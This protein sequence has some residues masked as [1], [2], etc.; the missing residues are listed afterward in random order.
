MEEARESLLVVEEESQSP[1]EERLTSESKHRIG[2]WKACSLIMCTEFCVCVVY[3]G[4]GRNLS[5]YLK[6]ELFEDS[7]TA[8]AQASTW[9]GTCFATTLIGA[10]VADSYWG[11]YLTLVSFLV[12]FFIGLVLLT[13]S[14]S[15]SILKHS[16]VASFLGLYMIAFG[17]G[18]TKPCMSAFG[19]DQFDTAD[20]TAMGSFFSFYYL[21]ITIGALFAGTVIV[22]IQDNYGWTLGFGVLTIVLGIGFTNFISGSKFYRYRKPIGSPLTR[23]C[24]VIVAATRKFNLDLP[25]DESLLHNATEKSGIRKLESTPEFRFLN[26][27]S[28]VSASDF[29][30]TGTSNPWSLCT[31]SQVEELKSILRLLPIWTTFI[32]FASVSTQESTVFVEQGMFMNPRLGSLNIPP[33]SL[34]TFDVLAVIAFTPF[35]D[36]IIVPVARRFTGKDRGFSHLQRAGIGLFFAVLAM[37][38]AAIVE[39]KRLEVATNEGLVHETVAVSMSILWQI[40]QHVLVGVGEVFNQIGMLE[41]FYDQAPDS[42]RSLCL[43]LALLTIA[44]GGYVT[45]IILTMTDLVFGWIPDNLNEG[46]LDRFFWLVS[47]LCMLNLAVFVYF[48]SRYRYKRNS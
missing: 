24:Q 41:F 26:K 21:T 8:A 37:V 29:T 47:G 36:K 15:L 10:Y 25:K 20:T 28:I 3:Y 22:W 5:V 9:Q 17:A 48:A 14:T 13:L 32:L 18:A 42:M 40:P 43:A 16:P 44:L 46:H 11:N 38:S 39:T 31:T 1:N 2:G 23:M 35:Y 27:A 19:A 45:S 6:T 30:P 34:T 33:A 4:V 12:I 7:V